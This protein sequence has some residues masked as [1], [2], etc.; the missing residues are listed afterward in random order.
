M[1]RLER[2]PLALLFGAG[3]VAGLGLGLAAIGHVAETRTSP[4]EPD[5]DVWRVLLVGG[6]LAS[7]ACY[8]AGLAALRRRIGPVA[9]VAPAASAS[10]QAGP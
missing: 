6:L 2:R 7:F 8:L 3:A 10:V 4:L 1:R 5:G 9:A